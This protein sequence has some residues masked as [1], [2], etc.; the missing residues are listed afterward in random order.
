M[1]DSLRYA[2]GEEIQLGD[3]VLYDEIP[4]QAGLIASNPDDPDEN[5]YIQ[6]SGKGVMLIEPAIFGRLFT[7]AIDALEF[8][9]RG[10]LEAFP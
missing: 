2:S 8:V 1:R 7:T 6:S 9:E 5:W 3:R 10:K 4:A